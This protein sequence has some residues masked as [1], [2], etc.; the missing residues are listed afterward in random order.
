[1]VYTTVREPCVVFGAVKLDVK[2]RPLGFHRLDGSRYRV[3]SEFPRSGEDQNVCLG[4]V[5]CADVMLM[6]VARLANTLA[7][8]KEG[9]SMATGSLQ[10]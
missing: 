6:V 5:V 10:R 2:L 9:K 7:V 4:V 8:N 1:M 3:V